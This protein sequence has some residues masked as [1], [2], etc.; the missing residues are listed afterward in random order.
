MKMVH[1]YTRIYKRV[2]VFVYAL[3]CLYVY[4]INSHVLRCHT[5][6]MSVYVF[7]ATYLALTEEVPSP[8]EMGDNL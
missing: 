3:V 8:N 6:N 5:V 4:N 2:C 7:V 1:Q